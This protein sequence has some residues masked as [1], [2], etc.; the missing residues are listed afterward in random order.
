MLNIAT[1]NIENLDT[2][3]D[4]K[5]PPLK[6]RIPALR[7][8]LSRLD[9]HVLCL[10]EVH[11]QEQKGHTEKYPKRHL[12]A[13]DRVIKGTQYEN[14]NRCTTQTTG[15][16]YDKHNLVVL[17]KFPIKNMSNTGTTIWDDCSTVR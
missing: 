10:Q 6:K 2:K 13:L 8:A 7:A 12:A 4:D 3:I 11:G 16:P 15:V 14:Y 17:S 9:A 1:F 5:N